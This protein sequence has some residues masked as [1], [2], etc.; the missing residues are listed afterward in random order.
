M[1]SILGRQEHACRLNR[2]DL[3][4]RVVMY[5]DWGLYA[6]WHVGDRLEVS[7]D[8]RR[9]TVYS[10]EVVADHHQFYQ[11][12]APDYPDRVEAD[13]VWVPPT[14]PVV[15]QLEQRGWFIIY[16]GSRSVILSRTYAPTTVG[17]PSGSSPCFPDP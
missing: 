9:E 12:L 10:G 11:G 6:V 8:N 16:R 2:A 14:L 15:H 17:A 7:I 4:G 1:G 13:F 5:F 3:R